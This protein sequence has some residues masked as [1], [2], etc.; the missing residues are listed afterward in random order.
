MF[1][2]QRGDAIVIILRSR[3]LCLSLIQR[4]LGGLDLG[5][6]GGDL[7]SRIRQGSLGH[8]EIGGRRLNGDFVGGC[9]D[10]VKKITLVNH[11]VVLD[12]EIIDR[13]GNPG[14]DPNHVG[15]QHAVVAA[16]ITGIPSI[17]DYSG[18]DCQ[19]HK[20]P[21]DDRSQDGFAGMTV[22]HVFS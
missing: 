9:F 13:T 7:Q 21:A 1:G 4:G 2:K 17:G 18:N 12:R 14:S 5:L 19:D 3:Q 6:L 15:H 10:L 20:S 22:R 16:G 11:L 8:G